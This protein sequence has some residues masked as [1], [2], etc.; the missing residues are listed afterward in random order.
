MRQR[1]AFGLRSDL[2]WVQEVAADPR[3]RMETLDFPMLPEEDAEFGSRQHAYAAAVEVVQRYAASRVDA[4]GGVYIDQ[5]N[6]VVVSLWTD[7][8]EDHL[9]EINKVGAVAKPIV[10]REVRWSEHELRSVQDQIDWDWFAEVDAKGQGVG[11]DI[12]GN[13]VDIEISSANPDAPRRI[14]D[15]YA[16]ALGIPPEML[17]VESDGTGAALLPYGTVRGIVTLADGS[18][19]G[20]NNLMVDG[21]NDGPGSCGGGDIGYGVGDDGRF[22][23]P[24]QVGD[25]TMVI[26][27]PLPRDAGWVVVG[28]AHVTVRSGQAV[29]VRIRLDR[30]A[31]IRG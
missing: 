24:C 4:F 14:V 8:P 17:D 12:I 16:E 21:R 27:A 9:A 18:E 15:H 6:H 13:V 29:R 28:R 20:D 1:Q 26:E 19:P 3:A 11:V 25:Y 22:Q 5:P 23:I 10:A 2:A 31:E 7:D 30:G